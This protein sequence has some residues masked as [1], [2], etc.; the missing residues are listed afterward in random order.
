MILRVL[1]RNILNL[2]RPI[3]RK[4]R[5][6]SISIS[7]RAIVPVSLTLLSHDKR[8][9]KTATGNSERRSVVGS[10]SK[11]DECTGHVHFS[12]AP[13][14]TLP[15]PHNPSHLRLGHYP[16]LCPARLY[17]HG[18]QG[19]DCLHT[20]IVAPGIL[21]SSTPS[22][23]CI[24]KFSSIDSTSALFVCTQPG[25]FLYVLFAGGSSELFCGGTITQ[26]W[27]TAS[28]EDRGAE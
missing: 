20:S 13:F 6:E 3:Q 28:D 8:H 17:Y 19:I 11:R 22:T 23:P 27:R 1:A 7:L 26:V 5:R 16:P 10:E 14:W 21:S 25:A 2:D 9:G 24:C 12:G 18:F 4:L 15:S